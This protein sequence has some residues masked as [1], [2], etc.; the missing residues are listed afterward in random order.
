MKPQ[1][2]L[3]RQRIVNMPAVPERCSHMSSQGIDLASSRE[4]SGSH[5]DLYLSLRVCE[6]LGASE[7]ELS[8]FIWGQL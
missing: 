5:P 1:L 7:G 4:E 8:Q 6:N 2:I 3:A